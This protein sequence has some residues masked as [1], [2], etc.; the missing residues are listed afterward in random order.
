[1]KVS[2]T[3]LPDINLEV[4]KLWARNAEPA[5]K[6]FLTNKALSNSWN[7][8]LGEALEKCGFNS[9]ENLFLTTRFPECQDIL[10]S[11][12][13][14]FDNPI[15]V[16]HTDDQEKAKKQ[17]LAVLYLLGIIIPSDE[18]ESAFEHKRELIHDN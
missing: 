12:S 2:Y 14:Y 4:V 9:K 18:Y 15:T 3:I 8:F 5:A 13:W 6:I 16:I 11:N 10:V 1:M 17:V 7:V